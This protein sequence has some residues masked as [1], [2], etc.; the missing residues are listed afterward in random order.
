M[1]DLI[2]HPPHTIAASG[3]SVVDV[4][5]RY[6]LDFHLGSAFESL[7]DADLNGDAVSDLKKARWLLARWGELLAAGVVKVPTA[8]ETTVVWN[9]PENVC[10]AFALRGLIS[11]AARHVLDVAVFSFEDYKPEDMIASAIKCLDAEIAGLI[12]DALPVPHR[13]SA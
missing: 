12:A 8:Y 1:T 2:N 4:I 7:V 6:A 11:A 13:V 3:F 9:A 10:K 5:E